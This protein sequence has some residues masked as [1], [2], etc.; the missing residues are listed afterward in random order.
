L[1]TISS[2]ESNGTARF[3]GRLTDSSQQS[4]GAVLWKAGRGKRHS[5]SNG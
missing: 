3:L 5:E 4:R 1:L 2:L